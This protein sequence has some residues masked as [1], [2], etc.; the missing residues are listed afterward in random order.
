MA[1]MLLGKILQKNARDP[2]LGHKTATIFGNR[3][4]TYAE[5]NAQANRV[6]NGL[7]D[8][9]ARKGDRIGVLSRNSDVYVALYFA[10]AKL[11]AIMVPVNFWYRSQEIRY[12]LHQSGAR[13]LIFHR[14]FADVVAGVGD[15]SKLEWTLTIGDDR[16]SRLEDVAAGS[17]EVEPGVEPDE[18]DP[19]IILYTSGTTGFPKG[20]VFSHKSHY[21]QALSLAHS[22]GG[23]SD[24]VGLVVYP[25]F[26]TGGPDCLV[27]PHFLVGATLVILDGAN[28]DAI[29]SA[30]AS[31]KATNI[32]CVPTV[33]R[34]ILACQH[35][36]N[37]DVTS[38]QRCLG[39]SD[40]LPTALLEDILA[41]FESDVYVTY[42]LTEA[43]CILTVCRLTAND[44]GKLG[45]VGRPMPSVELSVVDSCG[46]PVTSGEVGEV[47]AKTAST[48]LGYW[49]MPEKTEESLKGGWLY[50]GD[51]GRMDNDGYLYLS[52][53]AKDMI[54]SGGENIYPLEIER[55]LRENPKIRDAAVVGIPDREWGESVLAAVVADDG[56]DL[57]PDEV[58][59]YVRARLAGFKN[60][61]WVEIVKE[62]PVTTATGKVQK[63]ALRERFRGKYGTA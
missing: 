3:T 14:R 61:R 10:L 24:D 35:R 21:L 29:L 59:D 34:W 54:I 41:T 42:G 28:P 33:W 52:G 6:A 17:P 4:L 51:L 39:S 25:L 8:L 45:S 32:F 58:S 31:H 15:L 27:L 30:A 18:N 50:T 43:G 11:G 5:L 23:H 49:D 55:L 26:H 13:G 56:A 1:R 12:T 38:V 20:A 53:R 46:N 22:T 36:K 62:L 44:L 60:P 57:T 48:M 40:T 9:G 19:H 63:A 2:G 47:V 16:G 7:L 37:Y